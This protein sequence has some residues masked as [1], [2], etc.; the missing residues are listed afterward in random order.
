M[1]FCS[2]QTWDTDWE[3][4]VSTTLLM[5]DINIMEL[6]S[7]PTMLIGLSILIIIKVHTLIHIMKF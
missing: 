4:L 6:D 2:I 7:I 5:L 3:E 1:I